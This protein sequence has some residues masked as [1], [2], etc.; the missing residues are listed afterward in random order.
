MDYKQ[1]YA[2]KYLCYEVLRN[3]QKLAYNS[4]LLAKKNQRYEQSFLCTMN[5]DFLTVAE[6]LRSIIDKSKYVMK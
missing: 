5:N 2:I 6:G 1:V 4:L 3:S